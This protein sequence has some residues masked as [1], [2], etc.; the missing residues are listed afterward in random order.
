MMASEKNAASLPL[1]MNQ[2]RATQHVAER[3]LRDPKTE[4]SSMAEKNHQRNFS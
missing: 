3:A 4:H 2:A 1:Q